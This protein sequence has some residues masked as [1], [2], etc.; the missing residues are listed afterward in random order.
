MFTDNKLTAARN[1]RDTWK[2]HFCD[3][4]RE[5]L[6]T[7]SWFRKSFWLNVILSLALLWCLI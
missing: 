3:L 4:E 2:Q 7:E 1:E 5:N 6:I